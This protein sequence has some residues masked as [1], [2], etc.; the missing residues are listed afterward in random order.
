MGITERRER[1]REEIRKKILDAARELFAAEGYEKVTMRRIAEAI[2]YSPTTIYL[3]FEDKDDLVRALCEADCRRL[4]EAMESV[5][6][7]GDPIEELRELGRAYATFALR[8]PNHY[9]FLFM[10]PLAK[11][12]EIAPDDPGAQSFGRLLD[13][14]RRAQA[15]GRLRPID[16]LA[17]AQVLW[18]SL[19]GA[20]A[21]L[22]TVPKECWPKGQAVPDLVERVIENNLRGLIAIPAEV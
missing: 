13:A 19:H 3:H 20:V 8:F 4:L 9:R 7:P 12:E 22:I 15:K 11:H 16:G 6:T 5:G 14:V 18:S 10:T 17:A 2:E 1:E 21:L